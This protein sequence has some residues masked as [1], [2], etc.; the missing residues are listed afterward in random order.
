M[1]FA[2][3]ILHYMCM[4]S[5][6]KMDLLSTKRRRS[7]KIVAKPLPL[8]TFIEYKGSTDKNFEFP[9]MRIPIFG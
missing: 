7:T 9:V 4:F 8:I 6:V 2:I 1:V 3:K 5:H